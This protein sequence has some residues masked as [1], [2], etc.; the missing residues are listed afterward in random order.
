MGPR[1]L[2]QPTGLLTDGADGCRPLATVPIALILFGER[3][4]PGHAAMW[5]A[6]IVAAIGVVLRPG[7]GGSGAHGL[8]TPSPPAVGR[9]EPRRPPGT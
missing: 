7:R 1:L 3:L 9:P 6:A 5:A 4:E 8:E 2:E